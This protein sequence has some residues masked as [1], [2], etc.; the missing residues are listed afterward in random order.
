M[1]VR[2]RV[3]RDMT[4][5]QRHELVLLMTELVP[6]ELTYE[7]VAFILGGGR[8]RFLQEIREA[9]S[10]VLL[11]ADMRGLSEREVGILRL[12]CQ[13]KRNKDIAFILRISENTVKTHVQ[14]IMA[15]L[16]AANRT[17]AATISQEF[18][19]DP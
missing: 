3:G 18:L 2:E 16:G 6:P 15:K 7:Q 4:P 13:G 1:V 10:R 17:Q 8:C 12:I 14:R 5:E 19:P 9:F 11:Y